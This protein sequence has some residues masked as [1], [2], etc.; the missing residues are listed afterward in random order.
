MAR[1][2][3]EVVR[4]SPPAPRRPGTTMSGV[5]QLVLVIWLAAWSIAPPAVAARVAAM[6]LAPAG[7]G[8]QLLDPRWLAQVY[9]SPRDGPVWFAQGAPRP[10][11][12]TALQALRSAAD[13]G[14]RAAD[15]DPES[16]H[17]A[18][19]GAT[20]PGAD[21]DALARVDVALTASVLRFLSDLRFGRVRPQDVEPHF[22][23]RGKD[24]DFVAEL[25]DAVAQDRLGA[26]IDAAEPAVGP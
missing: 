13:R 8:A 22:R 17:G 1:R 10:A 26:L 20:T 11:A 21:I 12:A 6:N 2:L 24:A 5:A 9:R 4:P 19:R 23:A 25:R 7:A 14:L 16:L 18:M 15:Y 3:G